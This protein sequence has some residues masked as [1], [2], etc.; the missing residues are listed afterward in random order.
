MNPILFELLNLLSAAMNIFV[1][2]GFLLIGLP[3]TIALWK[4]AN[5]LDGQKRFY[6]FRD[7]EPLQPR[8]AKP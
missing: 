4:I 7:E 6:E 2:L 1:G 3:A 8:K 5:A